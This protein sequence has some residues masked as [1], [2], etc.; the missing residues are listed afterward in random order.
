MNWDVAQS[1]YFLSLEA[2][3]CGKK[4]IF[5]DKNLK[6]LQKSHYKNNLCFKERIHL[7]WKFF[8]N[9]RIWSI[10]LKT[11][12][13]PHLSIRL[14][15]P[16]HRTARTL[17]SATRCGGLCPGGGHRNADVFFYK[18]SDSTLIHPSAKR[19]SGVAEKSRRRSRHLHPRCGCR[20]ANTDRWITLW[21]ASLCFC[22]NWM[23]DIRLAVSPAAFKKSL[24]KKWN[25]I[26]KNKR[27]Q[28]KTLWVHL[29]H[30]QKNTLVGES[31]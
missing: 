24:Q 19:S 12:W 25:M 2:V 4:R 26:L 6:K 8:Y 16:G 28:N 21:S 23:E 3:K 29:N 9:F 10:C 7:F 14:R 20:Q 15:S 13:H 18:K 1:H 17:S 27:I 5:F 31:F 30:Q 11:Q 22:A